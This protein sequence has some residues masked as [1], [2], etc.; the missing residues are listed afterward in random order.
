MPSRRSSTKS[1]SWCSVFVELVGAER[2]NI[3]SRSQSDIRNNYTKYLI[4]DM[5]MLFGE[6]N[7]KPL[8]KDD[9]DEIGRRVAYLEIKYHAIVGRVFGIMFHTRHGSLDML[10]YPL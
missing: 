4:E 9:T 3:G 10:L 7:G 5:S 1:K 8:F 6:Y 2:L